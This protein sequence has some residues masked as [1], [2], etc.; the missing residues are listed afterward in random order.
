[1]KWIA[2]L[3]FA[4]VVFTLW[5]LER[6]H[7]V[8]GNPTA[9]PGSPPSTQQ[10]VS[11]SANPLTN[12]S[13]SVAERVTATLEKVSRA[14]GNES[15]SNALVRFANEIRVADIPAAL[16][17]IK[18]LPGSRPQNELRQL[19]VR[20]WTKSDAPAAAAWVERNLSGAARTSAL[21]AVATAWGE[22]DALSAENWARQLP[23]GDE[24]NGALLSIAREVTRDNPIAA[25]SMAVELPQSAARDEFLMH[26][27]AEW[28]TTDSKKAIE[29]G[30]KIEDA[31][32]RALLLGATATAAAGSDAPMAATLA[33]Q[34][35]PPGR[36]QDDADVSIVQHWVQKEPEQAAGWVTAFP[37]GTLR[38]TA[39]DALVKLW[40]DKDLTEAGKWVNTLTPGAGSDIAIAAYVEKV[41]VQFPEMAAEWAN[42]IR[43]AKLRQQRLENLAE[44][45]LQSDPPAARQWLAQSNLPQEV[46]T[47]LLDRAKQ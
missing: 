47:R 40:A 6:R 12:N 5:V 1:V 36:A 22:Q 38:D 32:L 14:S 25:L 34:S 29:W 2:L 44:S 24:R 7:T 8:D 37:P 16:A 33:A 15:S 27:A 11:A 45:W 20:R 10:N 23:E 46:K 26:S 42:E 3:L 28:A 43:D 18:D 31:D 9:L 19:L 41:S 4:A 30:K 39:L 13:L 21:N 17:A 35:L